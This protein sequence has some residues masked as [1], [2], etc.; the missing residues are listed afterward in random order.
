MNQ[1]SKMKIWILGT[2]IFPIIS[3]LLMAFGWPNYGIAPFLFVGLIPLFLAFDEIDKISGK[4]KYFA[5]FFA[6]F[7]AHFIWLVI[8]LKWLG[9]TSPQSFLTAISIESLSL[10]LALI[11]AICY[12]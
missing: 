9:T 5:L 8:S 6:N 10:S 2:V 7:L 12:Y 4:S 3:G 11:P 1:P